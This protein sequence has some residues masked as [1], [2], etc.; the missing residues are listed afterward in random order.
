[1]IHRTQTKTRIITLRFRNHTQISQLEII[2]KS[3]L[4]QLIHEIV[5]FLVVV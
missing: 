5:N 4:H 1:M 2:L 3:L